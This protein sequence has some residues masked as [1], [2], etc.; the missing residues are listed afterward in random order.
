M[1]N[2]ENILSNSD[3]LSQE[4]MLLYLEN[5]LE[6]EAAHSAESHLIDCPFCSDALEGLQLSTSKENEANLKAIQT[7]MEALLFGD[8][9]KSL[10]GS[11]VSKSEKITKMAK[12][13][14]TKLVGQKGGRRISW[15]AAA[16]LFF[17]IFS[18]GLAVFSYV[19]NN[20]D[21]FKKKEETYSKNSDLGKIETEEAPVMKSSPEYGGVTVTTE[22]SNNDIIEEAN[23]KNEKEFK[24]Q[25][26]K[27]ASTMDKAIAKNKVGNETQG[28]PIKKSSEGIESK[29]PVLASAPSPPSTKARTE[30][31]S[32]D[33]RMAVVKKE[34]LNVVSR[35]DLSQQNT[36][37][38]PKY[39][40]KASQVKDIGSTK[41]DLVSKKK[42]AR[43]RY[44]H[45]NRLSDEAKQNEIVVTNSS[46][47]KGLRNKKAIARDNVYLADE[48]FKKGNYKQSIKYYKRALQTKDLSN[49]TVVM[50]QLALA[51]ERTNNL[52]KAEKIYVDLE[53]IGSFN[54]R[55]N[56][57]LQ[58][59]RRAR[60]KK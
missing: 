33:N 60:G 41:S 48:A 49:K 30:K 47:T 14:A 23:S 36:Y 11:T 32:R 37:T 26:K 12:E 15:L 43:S 50:Y 25:S 44:A 45:K 9:K 1:S 42:T 19:S 52:R 13:P 10:T 20:T 38:Q 18:G 2:L 46:Q 59:V 27:K 29:A 28:N 21:F 57:G 22:G 3:C 58:R 40:G 6:R 8:E 56:N 4:Q 5:K 54:S 17:L 35:E 34:E 7:D 51:Y 31:E 24:S 53:K 16:G 55:A 39:G